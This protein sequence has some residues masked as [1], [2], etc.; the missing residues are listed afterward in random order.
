MTETPH[1]RYDDRHPDTTLA[2]IEDD[3][4]R[5][6]TAYSCTHH[7]DNQQEPSAKKALSANSIAVIDIIR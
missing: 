4:D 3:P 2:A 5:G 6:T 7:K 1:N